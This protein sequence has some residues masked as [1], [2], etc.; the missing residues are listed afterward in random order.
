MVV[1]RDFIDILIL[2]INNLI[3]L[4]KIYLIIILINHT[5]NIFIKTI[6]N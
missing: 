2:I 1:I 3:T 4:I 5:T 6:Y